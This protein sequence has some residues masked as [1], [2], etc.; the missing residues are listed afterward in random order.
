MIN[1]SERSRA[2]VWFVVALLTLAYVLSFV[3]RQILSLLVGPIRRD[4]GIGDTQM[5][6]LMGLSFAL[7]YTVCGI[8]LARW[9]DTRSRRGLIV[10]GVL[11]W[12][13]ATAACGLA[14]HYAQMFLARIGVGVG[15]AALSPAA[16]SL[17]ADTVPQQQRATAISIYSMGISLGSGIAYLLGGLIIE[18]ASARGD[19]VLPLLGAIR[20]WQT[21]FLVLGGIG[22][23]FALLLLAIR[24]PPRSAERAARLPFAAVLAELRANKRVLAAHHFGFGLI[25]L[26]SYAGSAWLPSFFIRV[27]GWSPAKVGMIYGVVV[28]IFGVLGVVGAGAIADRLQR[29]GVSD[30]TMRLGLWSALLAIPCVIALLRVHSDVAATFWLIPVVLL[31]AA[32]FGVAAA[33]V[34]EIVPPAMRAQ[35]SAIYLFVINLV[36]L[37]LGPTCVAVLTETVFADDRAVGQSLMIVCVIAFAGAA[38]LLGWGLAPFRLSYARQAAGRP[39]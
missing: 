39:G 23:L 30:A 11:A 24:E 4:L 8:P 14:Q 15:E 25:A 16:Y 32:P 10:F 1:Q 33:G 22:V 34:Q 2:Y 20:P 21:V 28:T 12:S 9:A 27:H 36:G 7:F 13:L 38:A 3:D 19:L 35:A 5:S 31:M 6:L 18:F 29:R 37:G 26:A 17:I